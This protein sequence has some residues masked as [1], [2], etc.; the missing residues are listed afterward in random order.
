[1]A[2][3]WVAHFMHFN[4]FFQL[5]RE[6]PRTCKLLASEIVGLQHQ[7]T[8]FIMDH[9]FQEGS[10]FYIRQIIWIDSC[11]LC[12]NLKYNLDGSNMH[13]LCALLFRFFPTK[14]YVL[15]HQSKIL[16]CL[17]ESHPPLTHMTYTCMHRIFF[18]FNFIKYDVS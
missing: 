10:L 15:S 9:V 12:N 7:L 13:L 18:M 2:L 6:E 5:P 17:F 11:M 8:M 3:F 4:T 1:M 14:S 16:R